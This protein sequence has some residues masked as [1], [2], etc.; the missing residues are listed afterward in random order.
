MEMASMFSSADDS[1]GRRQMDCQ[2]LDILVGARPDE[3]HVCFMLESF[4]NVYRV[5]AAAAAAT[6]FCCK[7]GVAAR[8][9]SH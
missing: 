7:V 2:V 4:E 6:G 5:A 3:P 9:C 8:G 1:F